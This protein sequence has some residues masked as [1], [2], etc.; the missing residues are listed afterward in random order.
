MTNLSPLCVLVPLLAAACAHAPGTVL[1]PAEHALAPAPVPRSAEGVLEAL[2]RAERLTLRDFDTFGED[3]ST[4]EPRLVTVDPQRIQRFV[5]ATQLRPVEDPRADPAAVSV[6]GGQH[7][8]LDLDDGG[9][10]TLESEDWGGS[11]YVLVS[12]TGWAEPVWFRWN[13][14]TVA[15]SL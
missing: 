15:V 13:P 10:I 5:R 9:R 1:R 4:T 6:C 12:A 14:R 2:A 8:E 7:V 3:H 11:L